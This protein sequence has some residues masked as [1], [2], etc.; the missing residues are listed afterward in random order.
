MQNVYCYKYM[1]FTFIIFFFFHCIIDDNNIVYVL[2]TILNLY[3]EYYNKKN[4]ILSEK[5]I[6]RIHAK[7]D[8]LCLCCSNIKIKSCEQVFFFFFYEQ[9]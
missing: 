3:N 2:I 4:M 8:I 7:P 6:E 1:Q 9:K 5:F